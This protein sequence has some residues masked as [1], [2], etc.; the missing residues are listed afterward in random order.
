M[1]ICLSSLLNEPIEIA[2]LR[3][4]S[5]LMFA[6]ATVIILMLNGLHYII[7][8]PNYTN[9][10]VI[11]YSKK[12]VKLYGFTKTFSITVYL[13]ITHF[14]K[15]CKIFLIISIA[16]NVE[17]CHYFFVQFAKKSK[18]L[19]IIDLFTVKILVR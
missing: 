8:F 19:V 14:Y 17:N 11:F 7:L 10:C 12:N 6:P 3:Y 15:G 5:F 1:E 16:G 18:N 9:Y 13:I 2:F 4:H